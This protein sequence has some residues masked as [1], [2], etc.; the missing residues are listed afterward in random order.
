[1]ARVRR[2][3]GIDER[4]ERSR[5]GALSRRGRL[6]AG[7]VLL[8][9]APPARAATVDIKGDEPRKVVTV[10]AEELTVGQILQDLADKYGFKIE[11]IQ[12]VG[13]AETGSAK[14][15]G[16]L[17]LVVGRLLRNWNYLIVRS[18][19]NVSGIKSIMIYDAK[20]GVAPSKD[21]PAKQGEDLSQAIE[22]GAQMP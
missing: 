10:V 12:N 13:A 9:L 1:M 3:N 14:M 6:A 11:G 20:H 18:P 2:R 17:Y 16:S 4:A 7:L 8:T 21:A 5:A 15:T 22:G 19:D